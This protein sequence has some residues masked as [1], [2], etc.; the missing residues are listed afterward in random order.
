MANPII[1]KCK[2]TNDY[3]NGSIVVNIGSYN[4]GTAGARPYQAN[5]N[6]AKSGETGA[7]AIPSG[8]MNWAARLDDINYYVQ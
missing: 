5:W 4:P 6:A 8:E 7:T 3:R 1:Q 2:S